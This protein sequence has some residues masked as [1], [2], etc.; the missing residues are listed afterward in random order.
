MG[1]FIRHTAWLCKVKVEEESGRACSSHLETHI[2][3][4]NI[5]D[6]LWQG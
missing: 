6:R 1:L 4:Q 3:A 5:H 2:D